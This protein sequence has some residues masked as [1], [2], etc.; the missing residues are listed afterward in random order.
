MQI[1]REYDILAQKNSH[2]RLISTVLHDNRFIRFMSLVVNHLVI[3]S[4]S[5]LQ[6]S[7]S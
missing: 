6:E 7:S 5:E 3:V 4:S 2:T 1:A